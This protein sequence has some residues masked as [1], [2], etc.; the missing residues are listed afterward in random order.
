[1]PGSTNN[2]VLHASN[3]E[4]HAQPNDKERFLPSITYVNILPISCLL[5]IE[6]CS[7]VEIQWS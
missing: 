3:V 4:I 2:K 1:M 6:G 5:K 7:A